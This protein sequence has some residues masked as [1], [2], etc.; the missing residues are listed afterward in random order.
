MRKESN[1]DDDINLRSTYGALFFGVPSQ[2]MNVEALATMIEDLPS[3]YTMSLLDERVGFRLQQR[4]HRDFC[5]AFPF[6]DSKI[7]QFFETKKSATVQLVY[8]PASKLISTSLTWV[9]NIGYPDFKMGLHWPK[10]LAC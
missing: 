1:E 4:Q 2:G 8:F 6:E 7:V 3:R 9:L 10:N 5:D